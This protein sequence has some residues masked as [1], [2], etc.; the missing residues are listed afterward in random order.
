MG[1]KV[2]SMYTVPLG[3]SCRSAYQLRRLMASRKDLHVDSGPFDWTMTSFRALSKIFSDDIKP[4]LILNPIDSYINFNGSITCGYLGVS[5]HHD[6]PPS[7]VQ[8]WGGAES[9]SPDVPFPLFDSTDISKAKSRFLYQ[10]HKLHSILLS[11]VQQRLSSGS[12]GTRWER[13]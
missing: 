6:L 5:F 11:P 8:S 3:F 13:T 9:S 7:L 12:S 1:L 10:I 2:E 4:S